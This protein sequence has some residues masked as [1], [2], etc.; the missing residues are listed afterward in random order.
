MSAGLL[1]FDNSVSSS[2]ECGLIPNN[3]YFKSLAA[4]FAPINR[5]FG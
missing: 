5:P 2:C 3:F 1:F 4:P